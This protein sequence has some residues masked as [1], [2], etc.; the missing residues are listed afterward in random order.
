M[1]RFKVMS[2]EELSCFVVKPENT[3]GIRNISK[4]YPELSAALSG[5][6]PVILDLTDEPEVDLAFVQVVESARRYARTHGKTLSLSQP[7]SGSLLDVLGRAGF[8]ENASHEDALFWL[9]KGSAQ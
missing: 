4:F 6:Q 7:A 2:D 8:I 3:T 1:D 9:L 5:T